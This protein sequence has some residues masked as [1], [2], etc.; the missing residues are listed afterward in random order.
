MVSCPVTISQDA[1]ERALPIAASCR[2][3][4]ICSH[5]PARSNLTL[6]LRAACIVERPVLRPAVAMASW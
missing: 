3:R 4:L 2:A 6:K 1:N 5:P